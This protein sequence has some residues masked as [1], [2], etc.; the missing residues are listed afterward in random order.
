[1][2][3]K[4]SVLA[5]V[6][7]IF[8]PPTLYSVAY[9]VPLSYKNIAI[10][11][12]RRDSCHSFILVDASTSDNSSVPRANEKSADTLTLEWLYRLFDFRLTDVVIAIF[13]LVLANKTSGLYDET[14]NL[15]RFSVEQSRDL[16]RSIEAAEKSALATQQIANAD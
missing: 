16:V 1:M 3:K 10:S 11:S 15:R 2:H 4:L 8:A 6:L 9:G 12:P 7:V 14:A 5:I 13:T